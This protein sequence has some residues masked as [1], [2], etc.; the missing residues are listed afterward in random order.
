[1]LSGLLQRFADYRN[2]QA[3]ADHF[4]DFSR[5]HSFVPD[6]VIVSSSRTLLQ[7]ELVEMGR[8]EPVHGGPA[9]KTITYIGGNALLAR[10]NQCVPTFIGN[11]PL[12]CAQRW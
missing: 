2:V 11:M 10:E 12:R 6:P 9:V 3:S 4:R 1:M 7:H 8:I 5:R